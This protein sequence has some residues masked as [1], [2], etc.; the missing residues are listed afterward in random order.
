MGSENRPVN[1]E[2]SAID[3]A[4]AV[5]DKVNGA[6]S[7]LEISYA[8]VVKAASGLTAGISVAAFAGHVREVI[9][10]ADELNKMSQRVGITVESL[11]TLRYAA[12]LSGVSMQDLE[13]LLV[14][15][16]KKMGE[17]SVGS[18]E[19][20]KFLRQF[21]VDVQGVR[22]GTVKTDEALK[23]IADR[24]ANAPDGINK[25]AA[26]AELF[27]KQAAKMIPFLNQGREGIEALESEARK[28]GVQMA[29]ETAQ[30]AEQM[31]DQLRSLKFASEGAT[32]AFAEKLL[33]KLVEVSQAMR[34]GAVEGGKLL[35]IYRGLQ[36]LFTGSDLAKNNKEIT[37]LAAKEL[38]L[39][40]RIARSK[41]SPAV[42]FL[43]AELAQV[44]ERIKTSMAYRAE[45]E[46]QAAAEEAA[47]KA[48]E[49]AKAGGKQIELPKTGG[50]AEKESEYDKLIARIRE[51][52]AAEQLEYASTDKLTEGQK[53]ASQVMVQ[54]RDGKLKLT[55]AQKAGLVAGFEELIQ[56]E[57]RNDALEKTRKAEDDYA[58]ARAEAAERVGKELYQLQE[59]NRKL[60]ESNEEIGLNTVAL[61]A[62]KAR[63][64]D[65]AVAIAE[66]TLELSRNVETSQ[67]ELDAM[68]KRIDLLKE[69]ARL[70]RE[71]AAKRQAAEET[72]KM[73]E[74]ARRAADNIE[75]SLTDALLRGFESGKDAAQNFRD[76]LYNMFRTL[77][78]KPIIEAQVK[79]LAEGI[80]KAVSGS[81]GL[82]GLLSDAWRTPTTI[83]NYSQGIDVSGMYAAGGNPAPNTWNIVG[84]K[85]PELAWFGPGGGT[86]LP[87]QALGGTSINI[88]Y[89][90]RID[91][92]TDQATIQLLLR[93][94]GEQL[95]ARI[96]DSMARRGAGAVAAAIA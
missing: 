89:A 42:T 86:V 62:L 9:D 14:K 3:N 73:E 51:K 66:Q 78:L 54:L 67:E 26:A 6:L 22:D 80:G 72:K 83:P 94:S 50:G 24:F 28:L 41:G 13:G 15:L 56:L 48:R 75:R 87:N 44:R 32:L 81:G 33:P 82:L 52:I 71:G 36:A 8:T 40:N 59:S 31:N 46:K 38:E 27:G 65:D 4:T 7:K 60:A 77:V 91:S 57:Q 76:T 74:E 90:P 21:G 93:Q 5:F 39:E 12:D 70:T 45:L 25:T 84:E 23:Q 61:D 58:K 29:T 2:L 43:Q 69:Q 79:P 10:M 11:S 85:G 19:A 95:V 68:Q 64:I 47:S 88:T 35:G 34:D 20:A 17:A 92:R 63:R 37:D 49:Q 18:D 16:N 55:D 53:M 30:K 96:R 1:F